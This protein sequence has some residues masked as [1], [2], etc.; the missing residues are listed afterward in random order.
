[1]IDEI[2]HTICNL[3]CNNLELDVSFIRTCYYCE[4][5]KKDPRR[6]A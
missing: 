6:F 4:F 2:Q 1:M 3:I 5:K